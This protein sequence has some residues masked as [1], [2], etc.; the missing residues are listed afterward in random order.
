MEFRM[1]DTFTASLAR[2]NDAEQKAV[3]MTRNW[4]GRSITHGTNGRS[5]YTSQLRL[6][7]MTRTCRQLWLCRSQAGRLN[8]SNRKFRAARVGGEAGRSI[9]TEVG[10]IGTRGRVLG[11]RY[12]E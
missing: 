11:E 9:R 3:K 7:E 1:A 5:S 12:D 8:L 10:C 6:V 2:L 4:N